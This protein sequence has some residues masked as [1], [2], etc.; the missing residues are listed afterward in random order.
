VSII[1]RF[2]TDGD[3]KVS[4]QEFK[5]G[6]QS[7]LPLKKTY[8]KV[9]KTEMKG[10]KRSITPVKSQKTLGTK[11]KP[12]SAGKP[13][14][15]SS[16]KETP[17]KRQGST[18]KLNKSVTFNDK[19]RVREYDNQNKSALISPKTLHYDY[20]P[21]PVRDPYPRRGTHSFVEN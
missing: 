16:T 4:Q 14:F 21:S 13:V 8:K 6:L 1:R 5:E 12:K 7:Q 17:Y 10:F 3:A 11:K 2:D 15:T 9:P 18:G 20:T 19:V